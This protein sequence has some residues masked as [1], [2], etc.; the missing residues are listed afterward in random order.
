MVFD[1]FSR[2][3]DFD[4][5]VMLNLVVNY[6]LSQFWLLGFKWSIQSGALYTLIV[7]V[8]V[9]DTYPDVLEPVYGELNSER[10]SV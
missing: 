2:S 6:Q 3:I 1:Q 10:L 7:D 9:N 5:P 8:K 4:R